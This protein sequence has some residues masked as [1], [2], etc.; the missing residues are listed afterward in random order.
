MQ[1]FVYSMIFLYLGRRVGWWFS[2]SFLYTSQYSALLCLLWGAAI[3]LIVRLLINWQNPHI[4]L[5]II[6]GYLLGAYVS[7]PNFG[8]IQEPSIPA[9]AISRHNKIKYFSLYCYIIMGIIL[10]LAF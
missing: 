1:F 6:F 9:Y 5:A 7:I 3:A 4:I 2:K 8:L 10:K